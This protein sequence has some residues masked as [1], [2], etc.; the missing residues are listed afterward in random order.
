MASI[1]LPTYASGAATRRSGSQLLRDLRIGSK[2][3]VLLVLSV[4]LTVLVGL[5]GQLAVHRVAK[6][7]R[8]VATVSAAKQAAAFT[9][10]NDWGRYRR[11]MLDI[12]LSSGQDDAAAQ[13]ALKASRAD[14][15]AQLALLSQHAD[16]TETRLIGVL[17]GPISRVDAIY[18]RQVAPLATGPR[19]S[20]TEYVALGHVLEDQAWPVADQVTDG[21]A[22][23]IA[24]YKQELVTAVTQVNHETHR[25]ALEIW[26]F[27][28]LGA[29]VLFGLGLALA[30]SLSTGIGH[31]R[32][33]VIAF[34]DGDLSKPILV[35]G[36][37]EVGEIAQALCRAQQ[38]LRHAM[39]EIRNTSSTLAGGVE[40]LNATSAQIVANSERTREQAL[41][42]SGTANQVSSSVHTVAAGTEQMTSS[43]R[44][45][46][47]S[48]S[49]AVRVAANA[50]MEAATATE[51][52][53]RLG[54][55]S[56]EIGAVVATI[57]T[58][59]EQ[60]N[61]LALNATIE[62]ARAGEAGKG[63]AVVADEVKQ[64]A[65]ETA[66]ATEDISRRV[67]GI[68]TDTDAA[69]GA[70]DRISQII[71]DVNSYQTTIA[72]AVEEQ[73]ATTGEIARS[74]S[75][76]ASGAA[77][78]AGD[79]DGVTAAAESSS[80]GIS[81]TESAVGQLAQLAGTLQQLVDRFHI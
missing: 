46:S 27:T 65:A 62:A 21:L 80:H 75:E 5:T 42:L 31:V 63:F 61:L 72:A 3:R 44:E 7:G 30:V 10:A 78:I 38:W 43:I 17:S 18:T 9:A 40:E 56:A 59:A 60:T 19:L 11:F 14:V 33:S 37:D 32:D 67:A 20:A 76:A 50:V 6:V 57:T 71:E 8:A 12:V 23:L 15:D 54:A 35:E 4:L 53:A 29:L 36:N 66:R 69:V 74:I 79:L 45:I 39:D 41:S 70:I 68:Q 58:I 51:T 52:V 1:A 28:V 13:N 48:S 73:T 77:S 34:A 24:H 2:I 25:A 81:A 16:A 49:E 64:L 47:Q 26:V 55:S 22:T